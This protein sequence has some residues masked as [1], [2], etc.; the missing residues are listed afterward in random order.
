VRFIV[1]GKN[2]S[3]GYRQI[4]ELRKKVPINGEA[5]NEKI[6]FPNAMKEASYSTL[7][8]DNFSTRDMKRRTPSMWTLFC[9]EKKRILM[10]CA[11][12]VPCCRCTVF[13]L[14]INS[15]ETTALTVAPRI[16]SH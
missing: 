1:Q 11:M 12:Q 3:L 16:A 14:Q 4:P 5:P 6:H 7:P 2:T 9:M 8:A 15:H 13:N 10:S